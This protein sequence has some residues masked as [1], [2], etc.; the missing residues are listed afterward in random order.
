MSNRASR[1]ASISRFRKIARGSLTT[2]CLAADCDL[3][4][5]PLLDAARRQWLDSIPTRHPVCVRCK[6][7]I[8][9]VG[10]LLFV[11]VEESPMVGCSGYCDRCWTEASD[12]DLERS[13]VRMI[14]RQVLPRGEFEG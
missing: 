8:S 2:H 1:R 9:V 4:A 3:S 7:A 13:A 11:T 10:A 12:N 6:K 14:R 5:H